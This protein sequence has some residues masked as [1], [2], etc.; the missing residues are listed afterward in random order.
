MFNNVVQKHP[1]KKSPETENFCGAK[2]IYYFEAFR[3][4]SNSPMKTWQLINSCLAQNLPSKSPIEI[5]NLA[6]QIIK[7]QVHVAD[8]LNNHFPSIGEVVTEKLEKGN[9]YSNDRFI[10]YLPSSSDISIF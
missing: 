3:D 6:G 5:N 10:K 7:G 1:I 2:K 9:S 8:C 4:T